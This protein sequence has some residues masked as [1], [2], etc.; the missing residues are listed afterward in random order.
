MQI[1][2]YVY[3]LILQIP[4]TISILGFLASTKSLEAYVNE[5]DDMVSSPMKNG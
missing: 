4:Y 3:T 1:L 2:G 5:M